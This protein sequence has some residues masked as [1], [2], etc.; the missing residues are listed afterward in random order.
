MEEIDF[1][2]TNYRVPGAKSTDEMQ[3]FE[4]SIYEENA[5]NEFRRL[6]SKFPN[7]SKKVKPDHFVQEYC[8][9]R[10]SRDFTRA[11]AGGSN[12]SNPYDFGEKLLMD[13]AKENTWGQSMPEDI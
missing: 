3:R 4:G 2:P 12:S 6:R 8:A 1:S 10:E 9:L 13:M 5:R 11:H 7:L